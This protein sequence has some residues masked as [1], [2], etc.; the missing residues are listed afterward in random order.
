MI[1]NQA[2]YWDFIMEYLPGYYWD[3][4]VLWSDILFRYIHGE[5]VS[6][7]DVEY[8]ESNFE[9]MDDVIAEANF[10][11][12]RLLGEAVQAYANLPDSIQVNK[13]NKWIVSEINC[14]SCINIVREANEDLMIINPIEEDPDALFVSELS[15]NIDDNLMERFNGLF[16]EETR[17]GEVKCD[18]ATH[19][20]MKM[21]KEAGVKLQFHRMATQVAEDNLELCGGESL[22]RILAAI[23]V[24]FYYNN[25]GSRV[26][27]VDCIDYLAENDVVQLRRTDVKKYYYNRVAKF[28]YD[29]FTG[30]RLGTPWSGRSEVNGG[31]IVVKRNG[32]V[33][34]YHSTIT[35]EFKDF[36]V[37]R[38]MLEAPSHKRHKDMVIEKK[39][40]RYYLKLGLQLRFSMKR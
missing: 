8:I 13:N 30:L 40:G 28:V 9:T 11:D 7:E 3:D 27:L 23:L 22:Q 37:Q 12:S 2:N 31:Y 18:V 4:N 38:L 19:D 25:L 14:T 35:D 36:L 15:G 33:V 29:S 16:D 17:N 39:D 21:L 24:H 26:S 34:A 5:G 1:V 20:R 32:D 10:V 6:E